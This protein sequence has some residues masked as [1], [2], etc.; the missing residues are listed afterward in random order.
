[1]DTPR[2]DITAGLI[3]QNGNALAGLNIGDG[4]THGL[5]DGGLK[6]IFASGNS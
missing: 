5:L 6:F 3:A 2:G 1:M 4:A